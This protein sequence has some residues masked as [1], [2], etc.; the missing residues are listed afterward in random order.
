MDSDSDWDVVVLEQEPTDE[1]DQV[2]LPCPV[3]NSWFASRLMGQH[4]EGHFAF[5]AA[6]S[7]AAAQETPATEEW[8]VVDEAPE[9]GDVSVAQR[10]QQEEIAASLARY[11][12]MAGDRLAALKLSQ[13]APAEVPVDSSQWECPACTLVNSQ[14]NLLCVACEAPRVTEAGV[15]EDQWPCAVCTAVNPVASLVC[16]ACEV[17]RDTEDV[18]RSRG[19]D[20]AVAAALAEAEQIAAKQRE[21]D[22]AVAKR[23]A[24]G[25]DAGAPGRRWPGGGRP[26]AARPTAAPAGKKRKALSLT[27]HA[28]FREDF[29]QLLTWENKRGEDRPACWTH[30]QGNLVRVRIG[31]EFQAVSGHLMQTLGWTRLSIVDIHRVQNDHVW[32]RC[33]RNVSQDPYIMFHGCRSKQNEHNIIEEGFRVDKCVSGGAN[34]GTWL[35][36]NAAYSEAGFTFTDPSGFRHIFVCLVS[37]RTPPVMQQGSDMGGHIR[38]MGQDLVYPMWVVRYEGG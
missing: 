35:A 38:V 14:E 16:T 37:R 8:V 9:E 17:P 29:R 20:A 30:S 22:A 33:C 18:R 24:G 13:D 28:G 32:R 3:C 23:L 4:L 27:P 6:T 7:L 26:G 12:A 36:S 10:L 15:G 5:D 2:P 11:K 21:K 25:D 31:Q 34:Y 19:G 1:A